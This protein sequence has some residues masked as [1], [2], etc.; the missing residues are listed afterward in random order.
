[1][2]PTH[3]TIAMAA[4]AG[5]LLLSLVTSY[6][7]ALAIE[8]RSASAVNSALMAEGITWAT[9]GSDG[10]QV[11]LNGTAPNEAARFRTVNL[12]GTIV[13][14][15]RVRDRLDVT[16]ASEITAPRFSVEMLRNDDGIQL[17][18]LVP[19]SDEDGTGEAWRHR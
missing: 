11:V 8:N 15:T 18:G 14:A 12:A 6:V 10:L 3:T 7:L 17:I 13:D 16:P 9:A 5:A 2:R 19:T 1:M 4:F